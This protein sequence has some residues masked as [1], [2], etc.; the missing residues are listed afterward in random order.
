MAVL[1]RS[2]VWARNGCGAMPKAG[3]AAGRSA[4][5]M[6][7]LATQQRMFCRRARTAE[8]L[9]QPARPVGVPLR[10]RCASEW[11]WVWCRMPA[12]L[13]SGRG[14]PTESCPGTR[15]SAD[16]TA[17]W[18]MQSSPSPGQWTGAVPFA[19]PAAAWSRWASWP[20]SAA[21]QTNGQT[22]IS[23]AK[24]MATKVRTG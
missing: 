9:P 11:H 17:P 14:E 23:P 7:A 21:P 6:G 4:C 8:V 1:R 13:C 5:G 22:K 19:A 20:T 2:V 16:W 18:Q 10:V 12:K 3:I 15:I 24:R